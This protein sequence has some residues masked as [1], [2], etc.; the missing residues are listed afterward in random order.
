[1]SR[2]RAFASDVAHEMRTPLA[3][4]VWQA[5]AAREAGTQEEREAALRQTEQDA[6]R[7]GRILGQLVELTRAHALDAR[8]A[9]PLRLRDLAADVLAPFAQQA[10]VSGHTL[11]LQ[12]LL[13]D[14]QA[15][16]FGQ[17]CLAPGMAKCTF[18]TGAFLL[19]NT[20]ARPALSDHGLLG[21][22]AW[23]TP[24]LTHYALDGGVFVAGAAVEWLRD[25]LKLIA[26]AAESSA[27]ASRSPISFCTRRRSGRAP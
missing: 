22:V 16:L 14:Q 10:H 27:L 12:G 15:A 13:C 24:E 19:L 2:E 23:Q 6:L 7:A 5:R 17:G 26:T 9:E 25:E 21:T 3:A 8:E 18:G 20:G 11:A 4:I 1:M